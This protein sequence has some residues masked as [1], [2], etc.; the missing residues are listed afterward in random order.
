PLVYTLSLHDALPIFGLNRVS[1]MLGDGT[2]GFGPVA[3]YLAGSA[4]TAVVIGDFNRD[5]SEDLAVT[6][7]NTNNVSILLGTGTGIFGPPRDR[8]S[9]RLNSSHEW[10]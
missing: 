6:N 7:F 10:I 2:G 5:G 9:T 3:D 8:K 4:P 1:V